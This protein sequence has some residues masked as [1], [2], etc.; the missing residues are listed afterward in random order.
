MPGEPVIYGGAINQGRVNFKVE[1]E[2]VKKK[3]GGREPHFL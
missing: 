1:L 3:N 2:R